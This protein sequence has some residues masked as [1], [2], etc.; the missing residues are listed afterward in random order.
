[1]TGRVQ[2]GRSTAAG[3]SVAGRRWPLAAAGALVLLFAAYGVLRAFG[4]TRPAGTG[5]DLLALLALWLVAAALAVVAAWCAG[6][7]RRRIAGRAALLLAPLLLLVAA[8]EAPVVAS[9]F[10]WR[11]HLP[12]PGDDLFLRVKRNHNPWNRDDAELIYTRPPGGHVQGRTVG[13]CVGWLG[14]PPDTEYAYDLRYDDRGYRNATTLA[15]ADVAVVGDSFVEMALVPDEE[16]LTRRMA[17]ALGREVANLGVGGYGPHQ[18][19]IVVRRHALPLA[20]RLVYWLFFEGNDLADA[21]RFEQERREAGSVREVKEGHLIRS[22]QA[23]LLGMAGCLVTPRPE[24]D[25]ERARQQSGV[26][27]IDGPDRGKRLYFPYVAQ[28]LT[29][30]DEAALA[31]TVALL[32]AAARD[33]AAA[34]ARLVVVYVPEKFRIYGELCELAPGSAAASWRCS[35][36][37]QRFGELAAARGFE[38]L[39]LTPALR[40][41]AA[42]GPL[43]YFTDD[44]HWNAAGSAAAAE[45]LSK[46]AAARLGGV[47][48]R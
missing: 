48:P 30:R 15:R 12:R 36:L 33:C 11:R 18:E 27:R 35:D 29:A 24:G 37:P 9:G 20:P 40:E 4:R 3:P 17:A 31:E 39:D 19:A 34:G 8:G 14:A 1:M 21:A 47:A 44:G 22:F 32:E 28:P 16:L 41:A 25:R 2:E 26:L 10:D 5:A 43:L 13:D 46:D 38:W 23:N 42:R 7:P 6:G 45:Q